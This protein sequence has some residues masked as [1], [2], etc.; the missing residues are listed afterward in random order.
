[1][2]AIVVWKSLN[3]GELT[4]AGLLIALGVFI[5]AEAVQWPYLSKDGPGPGFFPLWTGICIIVL[6]GTLVIFQSVQAARGGTIE[7]TNWA[8]S[9]RVFAGW[10]GLMISIALLEPAGFIV[11]FLLLSVFLV[12]GVFRRSLVAA[13]AVGLGSSIGF[14]LLFVKLL[15]VRLPEGP[16]GF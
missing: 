7:K 8:G 5:V 11:S 14:W 4:A 9:G 13:L 3:K 1:V 10:A 12:M 15:Q 6:A 16:W 2:I